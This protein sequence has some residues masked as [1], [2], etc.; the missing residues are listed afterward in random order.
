[1]GLLSA[2]LILILFGVGGI[3]YVFSFDQVGTPLPFRNYAQVVS[4]GMLGLG[5]ILFLIYAKL[6][7]GWR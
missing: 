5:V 1:M 2:G 7:W 4:A 3:Y 6:R